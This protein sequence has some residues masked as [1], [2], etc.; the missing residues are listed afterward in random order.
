MFGLG[1]G[2]G[3]WFWWDQRQGKRLERWI[4]TRESRTSWKPRRRVHQ[5]R[6]P[7]ILQ[8]SRGFARAS[9]HEERIGGSHSREL[10]DM[11]SGKKRIALELVAN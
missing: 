10:R 11:R 7:C 1:A 3:G 5:C 2:L 4:G 9:D 6:V 8:S